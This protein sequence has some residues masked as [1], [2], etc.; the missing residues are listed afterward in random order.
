MASFLSNRLAIPDGAVPNKV[1]EDSSRT[2]I[3]CSSVG[4]GEIMCTPP[5]RSGK[6][7]SYATNILGEIRPN[8][9]ISWAAAKELATARQEKRLRHTVACGQKARPFSQRG[10]HVFAQRANSK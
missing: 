3:E 1:E 6:V 10:R 9:E 2:I 7:T 8:F 4:L 5:E